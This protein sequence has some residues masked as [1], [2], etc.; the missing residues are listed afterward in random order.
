MDITNS[1]YGWHLFELWLSTNTCIILTRVCIVKRYPIEMV[2][3]THKLSTKSFSLN[4][5]LW[6]NITCCNLIKYYLNH[7]YAWF[8]D[9]HTEIN[10][11]PKVIRDIH[12]FQLHYKTNSCIFSSDLWIF[13]TELWLSKIEIDRKGKS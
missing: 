5:V 7:I 10:G 9:I 4:C 6:M 3:K 2:C 12:K 13:K 8:C 1:N 11:H